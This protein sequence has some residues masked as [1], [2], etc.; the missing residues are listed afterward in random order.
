[1]HPELSIL[2]A[3]SYHDGTASSFR[4]PRSLPPRPTP[5]PTTPGAE[6]GRTRHRQRESR[7]HGTKRSTA[8]A[9]DALDDGDMPDKKKRGR[10]K[11]DTDDQTA[12]DR[13]RTQIRLAQR[14]YRNRK[15]TAILTLEKQV[16]ELKQNNEQMS[17][18]FM[19]LYDYAVSHG[20][21]ESMPEFGR[22]LQATTETFVSLARRTSED[23]ARQA[24]PGAEPESEEGNTGSPGSGSEKQ[25]HASGSPDVATANIVSTTNGQQILMAGI[26]VSHEQDHTY[27]E[28]VAGSD[29]SVWSQRAQ[30]SS[31]APA[32]EIVTQPTVH[33]ASFPF[34]TST[35]HSAESLAAATLL[36][37]TPYLPS[38]GPM[39]PGPTHALPP[40][41]SLSY[42]ER[43]FGRRLQRA[44]LEQAL[45]LMAMPDP[46]PT[47]FA[48]VFGFCLL[49]ESRDRIVERIANCLSVNRRETLSN[50]RHPFLHL[51]G[52]G[53]FFQEL[54]EMDHVAPAGDPKA[55]GTEVED[56][57][58]EPA[59]PQPPVG[60]QGTDEPN[61]SKVARESIYG[62]GPW[63]PLVEETKDLRVD[64]RLRI[65]TPGFEG[66]FFDCDEVEWYLHQRG[67]VVPPAADFISAEIDDATFGR[68]TSALAPAS[69]DVG[70]EKSPV[71]LPGD[72][73]L[74]GRTL[75][76]TPGNTSDSWSAPTV[77]GDEEMEALFGA[78]L[79]P[80]LMDTPM[81]VEPSFYDLS[82]LGPE[83]ALSPRKRLVT[84]DVQALVDA[85]VPLAAASC[86]Y[87]RNGLTWTPAA[88]RMN[89]VQV[90]G[91]HNS[92]HIEPP[93]EEREVFQRFHSN[94]RD[95]YYSH[96]TLD[97]QL[98][99][100]SVRNLELDLF[101]DP[102][103]GHYA[104]P[105]IQTLAGLNY[106]GDQAWQEPG[107]KVFHV[108]DADVHTTC[109]TL[110]GCLS[111][112]KGWSDAHPEH[113]PLA[114]MIEFKT[115]EK[116]L[117]P[118]GGAAP[119]PWD[120]EELLA[121]LDEEIRS[122]F[123]DERLIVPDDLRRGNLTLEASVLQH[124]WPDLESARGRVFFLMDNGPV[125][126]VRTAYTAGRPSL[127][128]RVLFTNAAEGDADCAFRK[129]NEPRGDANFAE[130]KSA[131]AKGYWVRTRS[132][133]P[134]ETVLG[135]DVTGMREAAFASGA[136]IVSTDF[137]A[138]GMSSRWGVDYAVRFDGGR[139]ARCNP[140][141]GE[142]C[143]EGALEPEEYVRN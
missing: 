101:A 68:T 58:L 130:I 92:Y 142:G 41:T 137:Q 59:P 80:N 102:D 24:P 43:T 96:P 78:S 28:A 32:Y 5:T 115:A 60:N 121:G 50:W 71:W 104:T 81:L 132:D 11:L 91:T 2:N 87:T 62:Q 79:P 42:Q 129:L 69:V 38:S 88:T 23:N 19:R 49:F 20:M 34:G 133:V 44:A 64:Q 82:G 54:N 9:G 53:T 95:A 107:I 110:K 123:P 70:V 67:V 141:V 63:N 140:V 131:V 73:G 112:V 47:I 135:A 65:M 6:E 111:V 48:A 75:V 21:L 138:W 94:P 66:D 125:H 29:M 31:S 99:Y 18:A 97:V 139:S 114:F 61:R 116:A 15:E 77:T 30:T 122:V 84:I 35:S 33:N 17:N 119:I 103:G 55:K 108:A 26:M 10:P 127:E 51:G 118:L 3:E 25:R 85:L 106:S 113:V 90:V 12:Q 89:H 143:V 76:L 120:D 117:V 109:V 39:I 74:G 124:G 14:A 27:E 136:Q 56:D 86:N 98:Q 100:Q 37:T 4:A 45:R 16:E 57:S 40:P 13:R 105:L 126:A 1:M 134:M 93:L 22:Q 52:A 7:H 83:K 36:L 72:L 8:Q 46:P 128:G